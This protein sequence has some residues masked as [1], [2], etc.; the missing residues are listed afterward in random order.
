MIHFYKNTMCKRTQNRL[1]IIQ[2]N[3]N[4]QIQKWYVEIAA[5][6]G[7]KTRVIRG[8]LYVHAHLDIHIQICQLLYVCHSN[9]YVYKTQDYTFHYVH[10]FYL[11]IFFNKKPT[12]IY[13][14]LGMSFCGT[15]TKQQIH[16]VFCVDVSG[17]S[18]LSR[19]I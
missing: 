19:R 12:Y 8:D 13:C 18:V 3:K 5:L 15:A 17:G 14:F 2:I 7:G 4:F 1:W 10:H 6:Y 11:S 16:V 9:L